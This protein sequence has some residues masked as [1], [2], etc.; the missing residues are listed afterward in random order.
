LIRRGVGIIIGPGI[1][2][3]RIGLSRTS[4]RI[5]SARN[6]YH[7]AVVRA[8][9]TDGWSITDDPLKAEYGERK[10][11]IDLGAERPTLGAEK[12]GRKI[13]VEIQSFLSLSPLRDLEE[14]VGQYIVYRTILAASEPERA[15]YMAVPIRVH[16]NLLT[17]KFGNLIVSQLGLKLLV[18]DHKQERILKWIESTDIA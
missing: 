6:L 7:N 3:R 14:A 17:E 16:E 2:V 4:E 10:I 9:I 5:V 13:A 1:P 8:L 11:Y 15:I 18:F 12:A